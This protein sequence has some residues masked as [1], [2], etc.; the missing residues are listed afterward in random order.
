MWSEF[1]GSVD[2]VWD[3]LEE[4]TWMSPDVLRQASGVESE[5][6]NRIVNLLHRLRFVEIEMFPE[7]RIRRKEGVMSPIPVFQ[8]LRE[9][10][11][12]EYD[13]AVCER[14]RGIAK[15]VACRSCGGRRLK[16]AGE[17]EV[18]C[19]SCH[20]RQWLRIEINQDSLSGCP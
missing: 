15:R 17:N 1:S 2:G 19:L 5:R 13:P 7:L 16:D 12:K 3:A 11:N 4:G 18:E 8:L 14:P 20:E 10:A 6:L 9:L